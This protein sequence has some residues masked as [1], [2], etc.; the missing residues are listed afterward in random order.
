MKSMGAG[1]TSFL[2]KFRAAELNTRGGTG[3]AAM[4]PGLRMPKSG[5]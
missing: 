3:L 2:A 1:I 4:G 5:N